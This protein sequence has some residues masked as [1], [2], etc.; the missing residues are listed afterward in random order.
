MLF[1]SLPFIFLFLPV[2]LVLFYGMARFDHRVAAGFLAIAS[3]CFY[4]WWDSRYVLLLVGSICGNFLFSEAIGRSRGR[5]RARLFLIAAVT[6]DLAILGYYKYAGFFVTNLDALT[7]TQWALAAIILPLGISFFTFTQIAFLVDTYRDI[8]RE[9]NFVHYLLFITYFPHLIAGPILHHAEMM[10]QF[11]KARTYAFAP[12]RLAVGLSLF[13]MGLAKKTI[14]ADGIAPVAQ[15]VFGAAAAGRP[16]D[17]LH[18]WYGALAYAMQIYFD[19]SAYTDMALGISIMFGIRLPLNFDSPYKS[20]S[21]IEFWR[22]W[23]MTLSRFLRDYLY[24]PL[25]GS[26]CSPPRRYAN[27]LATMILGGLWH[28][29][30]WTYVIWGTLH[31]LYLVINHAWNHAAKAAGLGAGGTVRRAAGV[32]LTFLAVVVAWVFFRASSFAS[33]MTKLSGMF[34]VSGRQAAS[35]YVS[36]LQILSL[37]LLIAVCWL[38]PN[39]YQLLQRFNPALQQPSP[40]GAQIAWQPNVWWAV[41]LGML[42]AL[43]LSQ[44]LSG[45]P[46]EFIYFQF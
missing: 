21:I 13:I 18:A 17:I 23:H 29:A 22:R 2:A 25:G 11:G 30:A 35:P 12:E 6:S 36:N 45:A 43:S 42:G 8:A 39:A 38:L 40:A 4:G 31:G 34:G 20:A 7:G 32:L 41:S 1:N 19:F 46:S 5:H 44:I 14:C 10:P 3:L 9:R 26:R 15:T 37:S 28:G 24:I 33:A 27:L 16:L